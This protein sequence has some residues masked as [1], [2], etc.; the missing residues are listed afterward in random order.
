MNIIAVMVLKY[1]WLQF[2]YKPLFTACVLLCGYIQTRNVDIFGPV[3]STAC[4][5]RHSLQLAQY[6]MFEATQTHKYEHYA[7]STDVSCAVSVAD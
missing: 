2:S 6:H 5:C 7:H 4:H 1:F 3:G